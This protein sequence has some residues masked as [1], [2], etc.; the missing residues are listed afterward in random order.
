[1]PD[2]SRDRAVPNQR[3]PLAPTRRDI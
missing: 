1:M 3:D 2:L